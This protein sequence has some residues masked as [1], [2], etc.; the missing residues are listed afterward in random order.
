MQPST[1]AIYAGMADKRER[2]PISEDNGRATVPMGRG[3]AR[4]KRFH[5][6]ATYV[7]VTTLDGQTVELTR[8]QADVLDL[9]RTYIETG[10]V[11]MREMAEILKVAPSTVW[12]ALV[13]LASYGLIGYLTGRGRWNRTI[14][15]SRG[16]NDGLERFQKAAK[17]KVRQWAKATE[18]RFSRLAASVATRYSWK[19]MEDHG[20]GHYFLVS[21][22][23]TMSAPWSAEDVAGVV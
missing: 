14:L 4:H 20:L 22:G 13:K 18:L 16:K 12:R 11:T 2:D 15:F 8:T 19:E 7:T 10:T 1:V 9:G 23:A 17:D 6:G 3:F 21:K 5:P